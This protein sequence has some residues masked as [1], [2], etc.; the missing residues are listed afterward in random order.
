ME[1]ITPL[2]PEGARTLAYPLYEDRRDKMGYPEWEHIARVAGAVP[3]PYRAVAY[4]HDTVEDGLLSF[5]AMFNVL[6]TTQFYALLLLTREPG[7]RLTY[8][9]YIRAIHDNVTQAGEMAREIKLADLKDNMTRPCPAE[10]TGMR[11][12]GGRYHLA[13]QL[14]SKPPQRAAWIEG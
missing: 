10:M 5:R 3:V 9:E 6:S 1:I 7:L 11:E 13:Y 12:P 14:L 2:S 4:L 8:M